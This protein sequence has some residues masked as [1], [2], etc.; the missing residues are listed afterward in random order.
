MGDIPLAG[1]FPPLQTFPSS[2][3]PF[4]S[5]HSFWVTTSLDLLLYLSY[6]GE[7][8]SEVIFPLFTLQ[9]YPL[10]VQT[11][12]TPMRAFSFVIGSLQQ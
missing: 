2:G 8:E 10:Q 12:L 5:H 4:H 1:L 3:F 9:L 6:F 7:N 11:N